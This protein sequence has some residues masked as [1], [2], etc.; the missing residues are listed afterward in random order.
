M[1]LVEKSF[2]QRLLTA[3]EAANMNR[4]ELARAQIPPLA[5]QSVQAWTAGKTTPREGR[6]RR[7]ADVLGVRY[8]W[9]A[10]GEPPMVEGGTVGAPAAFGLS[11]NTQDWDVAIRKAWA[12]APRERVTPYPSGRAV[13][14]STP[15]LV[16][17]VVSYS[18]GQRAGELRA[19]MWTVAVSRALAL[20]SGFDKQAMVLVCLAEDA[21][22]L[23]NEITQAAWEGQPLGVELIL[24]RSSADAV[25]AMSK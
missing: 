21:D 17:D 13:F 24:C 7:S 3:M 25:A 23:G 20:M 4:A 16:A 14:L 19:A 22:N 12:N 11:M 8:R 6:V 5:P 9:L 2:P 18:G 1:M 10:F 15:S